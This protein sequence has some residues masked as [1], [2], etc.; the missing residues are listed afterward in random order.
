V[1]HQEDWYLLRD[2]PQPSSEADVIAKVV[3]AVTA[4]LGQ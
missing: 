2:L 1:E 3:P 4:L